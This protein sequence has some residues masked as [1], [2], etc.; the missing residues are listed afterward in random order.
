M[1]HT[2]IPER[3][4]VFYDGGC[5]LC[6]REIA[7]Y[8][9]L[10][11]Q[12]RL[13]WLDIAA[14]PQQLQAY[15]VSWE[16]AMRRLHVFGTDGRLHTGAYAFAALWKHLPYYRWLARIVSLP[17]VLNLLDRAYAQFARRRWRRR[18]GE[19]CAIDPARTPTVETDPRD[20]YAD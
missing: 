14:Q 12:A 1:S 7:H 10:D 19:Q 8:R 5:P 15:G 11:R 20:R 2:N 18:C 13:E 17:G 6:Q 16:A 3:P 9:R 4:V